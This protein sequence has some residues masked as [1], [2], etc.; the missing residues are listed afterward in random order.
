MRRSVPFRVQA[1][2]AALAVALL[3]AACSSD[4]SSG[5]PSSGATSTG[6]SSTSAAPSSSGSGVPARGSA[7][8]V[9]WADGQRAP[10]LQKL[11]NTFGQDNGVKVSVQ[12]ISTDLQSVYVTATTAGKGPDIVVGATDWIGNLV[13]NGAIAPVP[14]SG[15]QLSAF[16]PIAAKAVTYNGSVYGVPYATENLALFRNTALA[17]NAPSTFEQLV[18][19]G[20]ALVT[21]KK[22]QE[23][24]AV[25]VGQTG[26]CY[27]MEPFF[28]SAGG[29]LFGTKS[30]GD[31]DPTDLGIGKPGS[32]E[33]AKLISKYGEKGE[34][35]FR[36]SIDAD[37]SVS[38]FTSGKAPFLVTGP[39]AVPTVASSKVK[40]ALSAV[41][42]FAGKAPARPF[43][44]VQAFF[45][46][47]KAK[48]AALAQEFASNYATQPDVEKALFALEPRPPALTSVYN[49]VAKTDPDVAGFYAAGKNAQV[50]PQIPAMASVW[51]ALGKA[52]AAIVSGAN[53]ATTISAAGKQI[54]KSIGS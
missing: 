16:Q 7:D 21:A 42:G 39:W 8:L 37:N 34:N 20:Q 10:V 33:A 45:L 3:A 9:I 40:Y 5:G 38:L 12:T 23:A 13:Q 1:A 2:A 35:V 54:K 29:Y 48:N 4:K 22:A 31:Y 15:Q 30:N 43:V 14:L 6:A 24:L 36:R 49:E 52:E 46:S 51:D 41:P 28:T 25:Q 47:S 53:P 11:A 26:D 44:S 19:Q 27:H 50:L 17:P 32:V 18:S